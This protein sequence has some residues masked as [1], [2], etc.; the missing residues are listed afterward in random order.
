MSIRA[1]KSIRTTMS[2]TAALSVPTTMTNIATTNKKQVAEVKDRM[3][4]EPYTT[5][6]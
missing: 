4:S 6:W 5:L 1:S 3:Q 2:I